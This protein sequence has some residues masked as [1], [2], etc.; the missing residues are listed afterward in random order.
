LKFEEWWSVYLDIAKELHIDVEEDRRATRVLGGL[1]EERNRKDER[2][3]EEARDIFDRSITVVFGA[4]PSLVEDL[5]GF[6]PSKFRDEAVVVSADGATNY[7]LSKGV[8][9]SVVVTDL[10]GGAEGLFEASRRGAVTFVHSHGDNVRALESMV[11]AFEGPVVGTTQVE[12]LFNVHCFGG[13]TD[14][15]RAV[16]L[17]QEF[18]ASAIVLAGMDLGEMVGK[19][20]KP[21]LQHDVR[22]W[23]TKAMKLRWAK[24]ILERFARSSGAAL[25]NVTARGVDVQ[26]FKRTSFRDLEAEA[27]GGSS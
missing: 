12:P 5:L 11:L 8:R 26:G 15:D 2:A 19:F 6:L 4:G 18:G 27:L 10:D 1:L 3:M 25:Y 16:V 22:A 7:L 17:A 21:S 13:F 23:P 14:G 20:S 9:P 24:A